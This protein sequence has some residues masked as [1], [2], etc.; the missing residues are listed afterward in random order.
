MLSGPARSS[1]VK[2]SL[3]EERTR[4]PRIAVLLNIG[5]TCPYGGTEIRFRAV[6]SHVCAYVVKKCGNSHEMGRVALLVKKFAAA[7]PC[8]MPYES[9]QHPF[10][11]C[12]FEI[13][14]TLPSHLLLALESVHFLS[15]FSSKS[16]GQF[17][18][19]TSVLR[20]ARLFLLDLI[21]IFGEEYRF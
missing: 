8:P 12:S 7:G 9:T 18:S 10:T 2:S 1:H 5:H 16:M 15:S 14:L 3:E 19:L 17:W 13:H 4:F 20:P 6:C 21:M 11:F